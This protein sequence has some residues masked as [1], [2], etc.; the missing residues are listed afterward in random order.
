[1][2]IL[3]RLKRNL[4]L[5][6]SFKLIFVSLFISTLFIGCVSKGRFTDI[7]INQG[8][9]NFSF[10]L[11]D[12][13]T[14]YFDKYTG[15][16]TVSFVNFGDISSFTALVKKDNDNNIKLN[17]LGVFNTVVADITYNDGYLSASSRGKNISN[18]ILSVVTEEQMSDIVRY[19]NT[20][21]MLSTRSYESF[22]T[23]ELGLVHKSTY[24]DLYSIVSYY[25][26][27]TGIPRTIILSDGHRDISIRFL[28]G[29]GWSSS[30]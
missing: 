11:Y 30:Q 8:M 13:N 7:D 6:N 26:S 9:D 5:N 3:K 21:Y 14:V 29:K 12:N 16:A 22:Y 28:N 25:Y 24:R 20:E 1:M 27:A 15:K 2:I 10:N 17:I 23:D 4:K 18:N 19:M